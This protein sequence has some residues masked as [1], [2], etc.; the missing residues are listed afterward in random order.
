MHARV[1]MR[2]F[3]TEYYIDGNRFRA[4]V[5]T[6][7]PFLLVDGSQTSTYERWGRF[8]EDSPLSVPL[9][10]VS[11]EGFGGQDV[12][13]EWRRG[14]VRL[15]G[16]SPRQVQASIAANT[17]VISGL[18]ENKNLQVQIHQRVCLL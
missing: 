17:Y 13:V 5:D 15:A 11:N 12:D 10:D 7:S 2:Q 6:G 8:A 16:L 9:G 18:A 1:R 4:V 3:C 14:S